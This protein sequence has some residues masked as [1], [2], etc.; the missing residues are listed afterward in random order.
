M[1]DPWSV[2]QDQV[3]AIL[4]RTAL[5]LAS[6]DKK[7]VFGIHPANVIDVRAS[8]YGA[9]DG[10][11]APLS[12]IEP[13]F[14]A[15]GDEGKE[16][17]VGCPANE[18]AGIGICLPVAV[19]QP[20]DLQPG[21]CLDRGSALGL[22]DLGIG[23]ILQVGREGKQVGAQ[24]RRGVDAGQQPGRGAVGGDV[25]DGGLGGRLGKGIGWWDGHPQ[26]A[27]IG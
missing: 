11:A 27:S 16:L 19:G 18:V 25:P 23:D 20:L 14:I 8:I 4:R 21:L 2:G 9:G 1:L 12:D 6:G 17:R 7:V 24:E 15:T 22:P 26:R 13:G 5:G 10:C 3:P